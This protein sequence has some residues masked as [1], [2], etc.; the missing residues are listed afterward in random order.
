METVQEGDLA[1]LPWS[2]ARGLARIRRDLPALEGEQGKEE[3]EVV[4]GE[5]GVMLAVVLDFARFSFAPK[6]TPAEKCP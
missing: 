6:T 5:V 1:P 4:L 3:R 2:T